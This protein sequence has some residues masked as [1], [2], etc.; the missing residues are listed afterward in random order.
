[1]LTLS[2]LCLLQGNGFIIDPAILSFYGVSDASP[3]FETLL[4]KPYL[5]NVI[6][7][8]HIYGPSITRS[9]S[10]YAGSDLYSAVSSSVGY[11]NKAGYCSG[12]NC[13]VFPIV[14][15]ETGSDLADPRDL[16]FFD[17]L[18]KYVQ[19]TGDANDG[20]HNPIDSIFWWSWNAN[21]CDLEFCQ[22]MFVLFRASLHQGYV[23]K[24]LTLTLLFC[25]SGDTK[26]I[27]ED[28]WTTVRW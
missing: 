22:F 26:G 7:A 13:H 3:F 18:T 21:R 17:S 20:L 12:S 2:I 4:T 27:V 14:M 15:T 28:D 16:V 8:P 9:N 24:H 10:R 6:I 19:N 25:C 1:M 5:N 11:L 23:Y